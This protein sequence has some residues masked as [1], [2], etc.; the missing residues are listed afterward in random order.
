[1]ELKVNGR[2]CHLMNLYQRRYNNP[3]GDS[4][5]QVAHEVTLNI[6]SSLN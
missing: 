2:R 4:R 6:D 1:M 5:Y 3:P